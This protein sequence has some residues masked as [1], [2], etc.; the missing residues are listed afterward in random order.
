ML[1]SS[2]TIISTLQIYTFFLCVHI[3]CKYFMQ[4]CAHV[5]SSSLIPTSLNASWHNARFGIV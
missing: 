2:V 1:T 4:K 5:S 3:L